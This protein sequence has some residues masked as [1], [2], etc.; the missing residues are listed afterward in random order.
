MITIGLKTK[1]QLQ[2]TISA[3]LALTII[4]LLLFSCGESEM[5]E[6]RASGVVREDILDYGPNLFF[7][8]RILFRYN[9]QTNTVTRLCSDPE[10][11][12]NCPLDAFADFPRFID[13]NNLYFTAI[14]Y[15]L[16][17]LHAYM[18]ILTGEVTVLRDLSQAEDPFGSYTLSCDGEYVWYQ[19]KLLKEGGDKTNAKDYETWLCRMPKTGGKEERFFRSDSLCLRAATP[20]GVVMSDELSIYLIDTSTREAELI[21]D[22]SAEGYVGWHTTPQYLDGKLCFCASYAK[23]GTGASYLLRLDVQKKEVKKLVQTPV[24]EFALTGS[25]IYYLPS[26]GSTQIIGT[27]SN[28][29]AYPSV[30]VEK[31][32]L[33]FCDLNGENDET[34]VTNSR[35]LLSGFTVAEG[36]LYGFIIQWNEEEQ[37]WNK[38]FFGTEDL[39]TG[40]IAKAE[41][42]TEHEIPQRKN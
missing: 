7:P 25:G 22:L 34:V 20:Y 29:D 33:R 5:P 27:G 30:L 2:K 11:N 16:H 39:K 32:E 35:T 28:P 15:N 12:G 24:E 37:G 8:Y 26:P 19:A 41:G 1:T 6:I 9:R 4:L 31:Q 18:D 21:S 42:S 3:F 38:P 14:D 40:T 23:D 10:C 17:I 36:V 13:G